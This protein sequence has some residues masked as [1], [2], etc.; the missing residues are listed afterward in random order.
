MN[1]ADSFSVRQIHERLLT[2]DMW[3]ER[4]FLSRAYCQYGV[5][6]TVLMQTAFWWLFNTFLLDKDRTKCKEI[7][8]VTGWPH[9]TKSVT[10]PIALISLQAHLDLLSQLVNQYGLTLSLHFDNC[11]VWNQMENWKWTLLSTSERLYM[12]L[13]S[14]EAFVC[15]IQE[16]RQKIFFFHYGKDH[17]VLLALSIKRSIWK[18]GF[19]DLLFK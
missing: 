14:S 13:M 10:R 6:K 12:H 15:H 2:A 5:T 9:W 7:V 18:D 11:I 3:Q 1:M 4:F 17:T 8:S 16:R 19:V